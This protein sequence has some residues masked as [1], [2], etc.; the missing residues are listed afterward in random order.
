MNLADLRYLY[1]LV[2]CI[3]ILVLYLLLS[4]LLVYACRRDY[5]HMKVI[6]IDGGTIS[7]QKDRIIN[8]KRPVVY[9]FL[10]YGCLLPSIGIFAVIPL[11]LGITWLTNHSGLFLTILFLLCLILLVRGVIHAVSNRDNKRIIV[12]GEHREVIL[13]STIDREIS[14]NDI[15]SLDQMYLPFYDREA[16][17]GLFP[18]FHQGTI[19]VVLVLRLRHGEEIQLLS[20][21]GTKKPTLLKAEYIMGALKQ[22][23][24]L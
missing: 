1:W 23:I 19:R 6:P 14:F 22:E 8:I 2:S 10:S 12:D 7:K 18:F 16:V 21:S 11:L 9:G 20:V 15:E 17:H 5:S 4:W 3:A 24:G 13:K